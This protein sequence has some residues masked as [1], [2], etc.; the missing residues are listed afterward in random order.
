MRINNIYSLSA[1]RAL[2]I[3]V[4]WSARGCVVEQEGGTLIISEPCECCGARP[5]ACF[6][7]V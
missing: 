7:G 6:G 4:Y 5:C 3:G 2:E 1:A